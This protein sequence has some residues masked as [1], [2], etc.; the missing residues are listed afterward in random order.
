MTR[1]PVS[2]KWHTIGARPVMPRALAACIAAGDGAME[3]FSYE[4]AAGEYGEALLLWDDSAPGRTGI[5]HVE[6]LERSGRAAYLASDFRSAAA[7]RREA[8]DELGDRDPARLTSLLISL[9]R[10][11][12]V[13]GNGARFHRHIRAGS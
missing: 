7:S 9:G 13:V 5:D 6:L 3:S 10:V 1:P 4:V 8:I 12:W 11:L 2:S